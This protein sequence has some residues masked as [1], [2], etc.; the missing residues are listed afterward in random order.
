MQNQNMKV[1]MGFTNERFPVATHMCLIYNSEEERKDVITKYIR[2]GILNKEK[3]MYLADNATKSD[4]ATW[5]LDSGVDIQSEDI[6][7]YSNYSAPIF[8]AA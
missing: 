8:R 2:S 5:L 1:D 7:K 4:I 3:V 6:K